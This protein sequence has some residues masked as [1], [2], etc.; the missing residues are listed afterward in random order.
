[1]PIDGI[2]LSA[3]CR[4]L[5]TKIM[6]AKVEKINQP[7]KDELIFH[8]HCPENR[9]KKNCRLLVSA[10]SSSPKVHLTEQNRENPAVAPNFC[11]LLRKHIAGSRIVEIEQPG[12][13]RVLMI[14]FEAKTEMYETVRR[15]LIIEILGRYSNVIFTDGEGQIYDSLRQVDFSASVGRSILPGLRYELPPAQDKRNL[16]AFETEDLLDFHSEQRL[17]HYLVSEF[18]GVSPLFAREC[19]YLCTGRTDARLNELSEGEKENILAKLKGFAGK[20]EQ[21]HFS[22]C[23]IKK[24]THTDF[25]CFPVLQYGSESALEKIDS[26]SEAIDLFYTERD[27]AEH[28]RRNSADVSKM[29]STIAARIERKIAA[30]KQDLADCEKAMKY[31]QYGDLI[32]SNLYSIRLGAEMAD[33]SDYSSGEEIRVSVPLDKAL[34][35]AQNAQRYYKRYKKAR[36][37]MEKL[38]TEIPNAEREAAY[39]YSVLESLSFAENVADIA[40]IRKELADSG[41][42]KHSVSKKQSKQ[43]KDAP[44]KLSEFCSSGG[45]PI[46]L[47]RNHYQNDYLTTKF[48]DKRDIWFHVKN[49]PGCHTVLKC[50]GEADDLSMTEAAVIAATFSKAS[51]GQKVAVDYTQIKNVKKPN[52]A[53]AGMVVYDPYKTAYVVPNP[54]LAERLRKK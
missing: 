2:M 25:Y 23:L 49:Y 28:I 1:M 32:L 40:Q 39:I 31:K 53:K 4:E 22:P 30:R 10:G 24:E 26:P 44:P 35:P 51:A 9:E 15:R 33:V 37:A 29:L 43:K 48:A 16:L 47:G 42:S 54:E 34:S 12:L 21:G 52:G 50:G 41:Y 11:M 36:T 18:V 27:K 13:E 19:S 46:Y 14:M 20:I 5:Q 3:V 8:L 17:D 6:H 45:L 7:E 38:E